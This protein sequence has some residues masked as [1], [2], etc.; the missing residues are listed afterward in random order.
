[1]VDLKSKAHHLA[2]KVSEPHCTTS[3]LFVRIHE[4][5]CAPRKVNIFKELRENITNAAE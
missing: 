3:F 2:S 1:M 5:R 4:E